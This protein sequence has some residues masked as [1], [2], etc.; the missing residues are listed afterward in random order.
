MWQRV[1]KHSQNHKNSSYNGQRWTPISR[2]FD[3]S[4]FFEYGPIYTDPFPRGLTVATNAAFSMQ[5]CN[6][7]AIDVPRISAA[8]LSVGHAGGL[9]PDHWTDRDEILRDDAHKPWAHCTCKA[10]STV[11]PGKSLIDINQPVSYRFREKRRFQPKIAD[12]ARRQRRAMPSVAL[13]TRS[14]ADA[15]KPARRV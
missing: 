7:I 10:E 5:L 11:R 2:F 4:K 6:H 12:T 9:C 1:N 13:V 14:S 8:C 3:M 15:D